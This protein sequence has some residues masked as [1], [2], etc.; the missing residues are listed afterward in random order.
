MGA[1]PAGRT[2]GVCRCGCHHRPAARRRAGQDPRLWLGL[3]APLL[4]AATLGL[5]ALGVDL[6]LPR[7][8]VAIAGLAL[9]AL[10]LAALCVLLSGLFDH[11]AAA[12]A[13][14]YG[15]L[16]FLWLLDSFSSP[17]ASWHGWSLMPH[18]EPLLR[19]L[20]RSQDLLYFVASGAAAA[21]FTIHRLDRRRGLA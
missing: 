21:L 16:L 14:S 10:W 18:V 12:L 13:A 20:L 2:P 6:D 3:L 17:G 11:P 5:L 15:V 9:V 7:L 8:A 19:G 1:S 4:G